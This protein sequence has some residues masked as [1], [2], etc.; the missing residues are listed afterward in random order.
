LLSVES[1]DDLLHDKNLTIGDKYLVILATD[2]SKPK[3][4]KEIRKLGS[5]AGWREVE[6]RNISRDLDRYANG[7]A[8]RKAEGWILNK[9]GKERISKI[10][11]ANDRTK[12][13][14]AITLR[15]HLNNI[16]DE[17]VKSFVEEA[18]ICYENSLY[19]SAVILTW[20]GAVGYLADY[21]I[22][23]R[24]SEFNTKAKTRFDRPR[25]KIKDMK[26]S[27]DIG[28][29]LK[30]KEFIQVLHDMSVIGRSVKKRLEQA[31]DLRNSC[32]H[33]TSMTVGEHEVA[34]HVEAL[35]QNVFSKF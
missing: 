14:E 15:K 4:V 23:N 34:A 12:A 31:L 30:E 22:K 21:V 1:L 25:R 32:G 20:V 27:D 3:P 33:P 18:V 7:L 10:S 16:R 5:Q 17:G 9:N 19:R 35:I 11:P 13:L 29:Q 26:T 6:K 2:V 24:L 28:E 8:I